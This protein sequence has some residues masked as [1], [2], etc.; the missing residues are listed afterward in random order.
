MCLFWVF[1]YPENHDFI[2]DPLSGPRGVVEIP[3][4][5]QENRGNRDLD[6][7]AIIDGHYVKMQEWF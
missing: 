7:S 3:Q 6:V 2:D 4:Q 1:L 5:I